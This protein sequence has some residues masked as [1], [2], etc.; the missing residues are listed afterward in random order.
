MAFRINAFANIGGGLL[1]GYEKRH[2]FLD[3][4]FEKGLSF[5][6]LLMASP[7]FL[8]LPPLIKLQDGG[9]V[10]YRGA[11]MGQHKKLFQMYKFRTLVPDAE[12]LIGGKLLNHSHQLQTPLGRFLRDARV[13]EL[14]QLFN[15]LR[16]DMAFFGPRP[17]R[18]AV[19]EEQCKHIHDYDVRFGVKPGVMG[20]SQVFT[21][22][23]TPKRL[24]AIIDN[25]YSR[26]EQRMLFDLGVVMFTIIF[27]GLDAINRLGRLLWLRLVL[28]RRFGKALERRTMDRIRPKGVT[29]SVFEGGKD[30]TN[31][32][33]AL[34]ADINEECMQVYT[35]RKLDAGPLYVRL[36]INTSGRLFNPE[37]HKT[38]YCKA[39]VFRD[40]E[41]DHLEGY[42][43]AYVL[44]Y[45]AASAFNRYLFD[46]YFIR[47]SIL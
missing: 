7:L 3:W 37:K 16:G 4:F 41:I 12:S 38:A 23:S 1:R 22:H 44:K 9:P 18:P 33:A 27:L 45:K 39:E 6:L 26:R 28:V 43:H 14:P 35:E 42:T 34:L 21:P 13:D 36:V 19:Y 5:A 47:K 2:S 11:R 20:Y 29:L 30:G 10:F 17:E 32:G 8:I 24:R 31:A 46:K 25:I 15:V 40:R